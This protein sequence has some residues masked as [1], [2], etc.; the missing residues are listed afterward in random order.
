[1]IGFLLLFPLTRKIIIKKFPIN[2]HNK[3][4]INTDY[5]DGEY[6]DIKDN[7]DDKEL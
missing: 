5:I 4:N 6:E 7:K 3:N 2:K 1:M